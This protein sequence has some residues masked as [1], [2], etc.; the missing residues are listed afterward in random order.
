MKAERSPRPGQSRSGQPRLNKSADA[1]R[2]DVA[3]AASIPMRSSSERSPV[4]HAPAVR[5]LI[6][7]FDISQQDVEQI[8]EIA[9]DLK[10]GMARGVREPLLQGRV[11]TLVFEKPSLRTRNSFE[12]AAIQ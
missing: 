4:G 8:F 7:L 3:S 5:H 10:R 11:L 6:S 12:A 9:D 2:R 1:D